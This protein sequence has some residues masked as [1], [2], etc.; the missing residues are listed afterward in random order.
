V[1]LA[2]IYEDELHLFRDNALAVLSDD[3]VT[4]LSHDPI[5]DLLYV[6]GASG[7]TTIAGITPVSRDNTAV[8]TF[9]SVVDGMEI[10]Q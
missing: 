7:M 5:T 4:A 10:K 8:S 9:I 3:S 2:K 6:G 1:Q